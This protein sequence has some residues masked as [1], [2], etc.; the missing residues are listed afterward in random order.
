[1]AAQVPPN[2]I[3][4]TCS[5]GHALA[6]EKQHAGKTRACPTCGI[7]VRIPLDP[8]EDMDEILEVL[9]EEEPAKPAPIPVGQLAQPIRAKQLRRCPNCNRLNPTKYRYCVNCKSQLN[10]RSS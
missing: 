1:M 5:K 7:P 9:F 6:A 2:L 3:R 4:F 10:F 8:S